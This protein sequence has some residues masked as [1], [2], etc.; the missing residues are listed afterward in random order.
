MGVEAGGS[1]RLIGL[2]GGLE[3]DSANSNVTSKQET[4]TDEGYKQLMSAYVKS[5]LLP[6]G[7]HSSD[8]LCA[9]QVS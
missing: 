4:E 9:R 7:N 6:V 3:D 1:N 8:L 5:I 2:D